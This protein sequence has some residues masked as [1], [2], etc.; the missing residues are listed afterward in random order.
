MGPADFLPEMNE[1]GLIVKLGRWVIDDVCRQISDWQAHYDG[2]VNVSVNV[3]FR[4]FCDP[5]LVPHIVDRLARHRLT[6]ANLTLE[7][8][9]GV[10]IRDPATAARV[11]GSLHSMGVGLQIDGIGG[12]ASA[13]HALR[14]FPIRALKIDRSF[15]RDLGVDA[16][17]ADLVKVVIDM[18]RALGCDVVAEGVETESQLALLREMGCR[19]VQGF[20]FTPAVEADAA[21][22]LLGRSLSDRGGRSA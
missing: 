16:K 4:E 13:V 21:A 14:N 5:G 2:I 18:G 8:S 22:R 9:E 3:S 7:I 10:V 15:I 11:I 12:G 1:I 19:N 20:L 6:A 17:T